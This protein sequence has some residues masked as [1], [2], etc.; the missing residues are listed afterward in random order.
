[1][2]L[3]SCTGFQSQGGSLTCMVPH[4]Y[5]RNCSDS[6][7]VRHL[8][9]SLWPAFFIHVLLHVNASIS[10]SRV[11]DQILI[12]I[13]NNALFLSRM[14]VVI[15][16]CVV[17]GVKYFLFKMVNPVQVFVCYSVCPVFKNNSI[18]LTSIGE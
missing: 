1:M 10:G 7:L 2:P 14:T 4:L 6:P 3:N 12:Q 5:A 13:L 8:L 16:A 17:T 18:T 9:T 15:G 11:Q